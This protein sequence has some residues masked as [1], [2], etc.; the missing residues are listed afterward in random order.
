MEKIIHILINHIGERKQYFIYYDNGEETVTVGLPVGEWSKASII[1]ALVRS[2][3]SQDSVEAIINNHFLNISEWLDKKF[4]GETVE[5]EDPDYA[6][7]QRWRNKSKEF[8]NIALEQ[9]PEY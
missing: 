9:F 1:N 5:F 3:Y 6:E 7:L 8:A 4:N 2:K